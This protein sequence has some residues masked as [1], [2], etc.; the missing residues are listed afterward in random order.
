MK[1]QTQREKRRAEARRLAESN[2]ILEKQEQ[3][4]Y[5]KKTALAVEKERYNW[6]RRRKN[7]TFF[8]FFLFFMVGVLPFCLK[9]KEEHM[10]PIHLDG[11][12]T[13]TTFVCAWV[14]LLGIAIVITLLFISF[15]RDRYEMSASF[16]RTKHLESYY[17]TMESIAHS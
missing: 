10:Y 17:A 11:V 9:V 7:R 13:W 5:E 15:F 2:I 8:Q 14:A 4:A 3:L 16:L 12:H 6:Y 1:K